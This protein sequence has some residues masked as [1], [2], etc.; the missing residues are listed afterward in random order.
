MEQELDY[1]QR[2]RLSNIRPHNYRIKWVDS[3]KYIPKSY[4]QIPLYKHSDATKTV[5]AIFDWISGTELDKR[6]FL[7]PEYNGGIWT[8]VLAFCE[9][10]GHVANIICLPIKRG[11]DIRPII[12]KI[13]PDQ[14]LLSGFGLINPFLPIKYQ[15]V[16][17]RIPGC[18]RGRHFTYKDIPIAATFSLEY[19][20]D[21]NQKI[22]RN[23]ANVIGLFARDIDHILYGKNRYTLPQSNELQAKFIMTIDEWKSFYKKLKEA[24]VVSVDTETDNLNRVINNRILTVHFTLQKEQLIGYCLPLFHRETPFKASELEI[25]KKDLADWFQFGESE[26]LIF[27]N[28]KFDLIQFR[29]ELKISYIKHDLFDISS[30]EF[31]LDENRKFIGD[32]KASL[33]GMKG[34]YT[35]E[36]LALNYGGEAYLETEGIG[37]KDRANMAEQSLQDIGKYGAK[38][39]ILP[40]KIAQF[41]IREAK[42]RGEDYKG[43]RN[44]VIKLTSDITH[45]FTEMECNGALVDDKYLREMLS[46]AGP[47]M[48]RLKELKESFKKFRSARRTNKILIEKTGK[49]YAKGL[50]GDVETQWHFDIDKAD[51]LQKLFIEVL[52]LPILQYRKD[53]GA[54]LD[55]VFVKEYEKA[56]PEVGR[57]SEYRGL[58]TLKN[59][60]VKGMYKYLTEL[61]DCSDSRLRANYGFL[62]IITLRSSSSS[63]NL[64]N[65]PSRG[66]NAKLIKREFIASRWKLLVKGDF[67]A[68][69][70]RGLANVALDKN[71]AKAFQ[72]GIEVRRKLRII[73]NDDPEL[74]KDVLDELKLVNWKEIKTGP[75]KLKIA[76]ASKFK[77]QLLEIVELESRGDIHRMNRSLFYKVPAIQVTDEE[78]T[79]VKTIGF[80]V[81]YSKGAPSLAK[82]LFYEQVRKI[83][84]QF[85]PRTPEYNEAMAP[86]IKDAQDLINTFFHNFHTA[87]EW[88]DNL[89][90]QSKNDLQAITRFGVVRHLT[91]YLHT[92]NQV[93]KQMA[94]RAPNTLIQGPSSQ[95]G[96][97]GARILQHINFELRQKGIDTGWVHSNFVHD[98][99]EQESYIDMLPLTAYYLEHAMTSQVYARCRDVYDWTM[100]VTLE[101]DLELGGS[102]GTTMKWDYTRTTMEK[103]LDREIDWMGEELGYELP[104]KKLIRAALHNWDL[105]WPYRK[106]ELEQ[107][108][109]YGPSDIMLLTPKEAKKLPWKVLERT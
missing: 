6:K 50:F 26:F 71:L 33:Q 100:P 8:N 21:L 85:E 66:K 90:T 93:I 76:N 79:Q 109:G 69:E 106:K 91:S 13:K 56:V 39:V 92:E 48:N 44:A 42:R 82:E 10:Q 25:I 74:H 11:T 36:H 73:F 53:G 78:R 70:M 54:K 94:R 77:K 9:A 65:I 27:Q 38:D 89:Q 22:Y 84:K 19:V 103:A 30:A 31:L 99:L 96:Y 88:I 60:F 55:K 101:F 40:Y 34:I 37:K 62:G 59:T 95:I 61:P 23:A 14:I 51:H 5:L 87:K 108:K 29:R 75:E 1:K 15:E 86:Y 46:P 12:E 68:H 97:S 80:G 45:V 81:A 72:P 18:I 7:I 67:N 105:I 83:E 102:L 104:K 35:L 32:A 49:N 64:Q 43:Y 41:Q 52:Q 28:A 17:T 16:M 98:S 3:N 107:M 4:L 58:K 57:L 24:K 63:P 2:A 47:F 20:A